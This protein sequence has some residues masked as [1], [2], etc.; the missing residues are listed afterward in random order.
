MTAKNVR[1]PSLPN[2]TYFTPLWLARQCCEI[3]IPEVCEPGLI[4]EPSAGQG[5]F[6]GCVREAYPDAVL[7]GLDREPSDQWP[8]GGI[9]G[10][11]LAPHSVE[12]L[13]TLADRHGADRWDLVIG[14]PPYSFALE[15][16][17]QSLAL[18]DNV[19]FLLR[20]GFL[21]SARRHDFFRE[22]CPSHVFIVP[23]RPS[24][25]GD[26]RTDSADYCVVAWMRGVGAPTTL[27]WLPLVPREVRRG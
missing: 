4:L 18:A 6:L 2:D 9:R 1:R 27:H 20:Q 15:F 26:N 21:S 22:H 5:V 11:Y 19:I 7:Y 10:D 12:A 13:M 16:I 17:R 23:H 8:C 3:V 24:F 25:T 14:N